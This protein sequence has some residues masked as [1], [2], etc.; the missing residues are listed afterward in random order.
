MLEYFLTAA[1][2]L[3]NSYDVLGLLVGM[4]FSSSILP[5]PSEAILVYAGT[6][7]IPL[8]NIVIFG[9]IG[10]SLGSV[11]GYY[12]GSSCVSFL[13]K[14]GKYFLI[15]PETLK[16]TEYWFKKLDNFGII[17]ARVIP[18]IPYKIFSIACGFGKVNFR[19]FL[20]FTLIGSIPRCFL[21]SSFGY[22]IS[23]AKNPFLIVISVGIFFILPFL[24]ER[25]SKR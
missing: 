8:M 12:L 14:Y 24:I 6:V 9:S 13:K 1:K 15:N 2:S 7:G 5:I 11:V 4:F 16:F 10:A 21:L 17:V 19:N 3:I 25:M 22:L 20:I 23:L 18:F